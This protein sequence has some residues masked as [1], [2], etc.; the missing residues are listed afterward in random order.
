VT[1][2]RVIAAHLCAVAVVACGKQ[3][4]TGGGPA[5][6]TDTLQLIPVATTL[7]NPDYLTAPP[8]DVNRLFVV[9]QAGRI[10]VIQNGQL[11]ATP[12][13]DIVNRVSSGG[14]RGLFSVAFHPSYGGN[15]FFYVDYTDVGGDTRVERYTVSADSNV[16]DSASHK[17]ILFVKQPYANHNGGLVV[18]GPDGMLYIG[19]G[20]GGDAGD[21]QNRAQNRDSLL[22]KLLR[23][24]VNTGD[25]TPYRIPRDNPY[26]AGGGRGEI[27]AIGLRNPWRFAFDP[28]GGLLYVADVGQNLWEEVD[29]QP[30]SQA[31]VNYGWPTLE[32]THCYKPPIACLPLGVLPALEYSHSD[33]CSIIGG[34]VYRGTRSPGLVGHYFYSDFCSGWIRSF[35]YAGGAL[36]GRTNWSLN[37]NLGNV[38]S[39]GQDAAGELYVLSV[40]GVYRLSAP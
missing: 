20:D 31:G 10:R 34:L 39:F 28:P 12:F 27:W 19:T 13:L 17:L 18:F 38:L 14:E 35:T 25:T 3:S 15:G 5:P 2:A 24:D 40:S 1:V 33:G 16:A 22:G 7:S 30:A 9:E 6:T 26:A 36:A 23:I 21:P 11:V 37:V 4:P 29:V 32:G 8:G